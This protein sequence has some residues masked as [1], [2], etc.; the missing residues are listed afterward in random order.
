M[1]KKITVGNGMILLLLYV[2]FMASTLGIQIVML[3]PGSL[4]YI[5]SVAFGTILKVLSY[6]LIGIV[7]LILGWS[8]GKG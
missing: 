1:D 5:L 4:A 7:A 8:L 3:S 6:T 2:I